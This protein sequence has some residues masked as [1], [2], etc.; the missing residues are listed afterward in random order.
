LNKNFHACSIIRPTK[1]KALPWA[2]EGLIRRW[3]GYRADIGFS[4]LRDLA[5][6]ADEARRG[7]DF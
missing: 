1:P 6:D 7:F 2:I 4:S 3:A 5:E